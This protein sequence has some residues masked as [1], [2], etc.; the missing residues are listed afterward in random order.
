MS[1]THTWAIL[2]A[3]YSWYA[4]WILIFEYLQ[5]P[6]T[7][8]VILTIL[9]VADFFAWISKQIRLDPKGLSSHRAWIWL[10]KKIWT[11]WS[12]FTIA[13]VI[14]GVSPEISF[15]FYLTWFISLLIVAE[16]YSVLQN[17]YVIRTWEDVT[18]YDVVS[19][20]IKRVWEWFIKIIEK[21]IWKQ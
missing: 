11:L 20:V 17:I 10:M 21:F 5:I 13:L 19:L 6:S 12:I 7:Q 8:I 15:D 3:K 4:S 9:M 14:A 18:E 16:G 1:A 2:T